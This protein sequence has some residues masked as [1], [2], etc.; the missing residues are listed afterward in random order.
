MYQK[1]L[2][3]G[4]ICWSYFNITGVQFFETVYVHMQHHMYNYN[5]VMILL[6]VWQLE[7]VQCV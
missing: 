5:Y 1:L 2:I 3:L 6:P 7:C 4:H